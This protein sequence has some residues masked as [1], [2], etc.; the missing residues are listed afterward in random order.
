MTTPLNLYALLGLNPEGRAYTPEAIHAAWRGAAKST[1]PDAPGGSVEAFLRVRA[2]YATLSDPE[3]RARYDR[4]GEADPTEPDNTTSEVLAMVHQAI[5]ALLNNEGLD[6][7]HADA[8]HLM[9]TIIDSALS[10]LRADRIRR[11][12]Q[13]ARL[14]RF[15]DG[16]RRKKPVTEEDPDL[17]TATLTQRVRRLEGQLD[18]MNSA[19]KRMMSA[20]AYV[21]GYEYTPGYGLTLFAPPHSL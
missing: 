11:Q 15:R 10:N 4:T 19:E 17:L 14:T 21:E 12:G 16:F 9:L 6:L 20:H 13:L 5:D 7:D 8:V 2:A 1:H 3:A 18:D